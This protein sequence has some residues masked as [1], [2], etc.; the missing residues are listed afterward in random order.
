MAQADNYYFDKFT[1]REVDVGDVRASIRQDQAFGAGQLGHVLEEYSQAELKKANKIQFADGKEMD[2]LGNPKTHR[3][4]SAFEGEVVSEL[5][6]RPATSREG[7]IRLK[8]LIKL[9]SDTATSDTTLN[10]ILLLQADR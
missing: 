1:K 2:A 4:G 5:L 7:G 6:K 10:L 9:T 8:A 3:E